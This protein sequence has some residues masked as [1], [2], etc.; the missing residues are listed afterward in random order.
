MRYYFVLLAA[1]FLANISS[2]QINVSI[3]LGSQPVWGPTGY[4]Y[5]EYYYLPDIEVYY[6]VPKHRFYYYE[7]NKWIYRS[8]LPSRYSN[9]DYYNS[10]KVVVNEREPW[11]N[12]KTYREKY[13]SYKDRHDQQPIRDSRDS[14][15]YIIKNHPEHDNWIQKQKSDKKSNKS[16]NKIYKKNDKQNKRENSKK[17]NN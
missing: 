1:L 3:N 2:A 9:Y 4:D 8:S 10:Y 12:H 14:K 15:Y 16:S 13:Y 5:V 7:N 17:K 11:H 6:Y